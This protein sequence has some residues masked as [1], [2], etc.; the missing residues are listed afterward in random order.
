M[1]LEAARLVELA[2]R[3]AASLA[4][5]AIG[6]FILTKGTEH[7]IKQIKSTPSGGALT[8]K[9]AGILSFLMT[10]LYYLPGWSVIILGIITSYRTI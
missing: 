6:S 2:I 4:L 3:I 5:I 7:A 10:L 1:S 8:G 9:R